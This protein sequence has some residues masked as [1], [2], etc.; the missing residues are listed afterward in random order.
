MAISQTER[1]LIM[2]T[3]RAAEIANEQIRQAS[4]Q[5]K[6]T[7]EPL[8]AIHDT[9]KDMKNVLNEILELLRKRV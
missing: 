8:Y 6:S 9:L 2:Q 7:T 4:L 5:Y 3:N 1:T